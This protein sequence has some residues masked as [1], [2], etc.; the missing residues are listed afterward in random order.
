MCVT[1]TPT[2]ECRRYR[3]AHRALI[4]RGLCRRYAKPAALP[5]YTQCNTAS[6]TLV[7]QCNPLHPYYT[8]SLSDSGV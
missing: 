1:N 8:L 3:G 2:G 7:Y 4:R 5:S 6:V